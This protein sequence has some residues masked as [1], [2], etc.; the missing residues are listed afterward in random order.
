M[1]KNYV[2]AVVV[3]VGIHAKILTAALHVLEKFSHFHSSTTA[4]QTG[5]CLWF[6]TYIETQYT[7]KHFTLA[8]KSSA[9]IRLFCGLRR[10]PLK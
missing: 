3:L 7:F 2:T 8:V 6:M 9:I 5:L 1:A 10:V 4:S